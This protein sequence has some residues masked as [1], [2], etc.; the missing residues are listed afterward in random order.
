M[1]V[2]NVLATLGALAAMSEGIALKERAEFDF[3]DLH[4]KIESLKT[5]NSH[6]MHRVSSDR[7]HE[8]GTRLEASAMMAMHSQEVG[9]QNWWGWWVTAVID[10]VSDLVQDVAEDAQEWMEDAHQNVNEWID[11]VA[12]DVREFVDEAI[13]DVHEWSE[14]ISNGDFGELA[15]DLHNWIGDANGIINDAIDG[16]IDGSRDFIRDVHEDI[17]ETVDDVA[18]DIG[19]IIDGTYDPDQDYREDLTPDAFMPIRPEEG[20]IMPSMPPIEP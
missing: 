18:D 15:D 9:V 8:I 17:S 20:S 6:L 12:A 4:A 14:H 3:N 7:Q 13:E 10:V 1:K 16:A 2:F 5:M 19:R 11:E